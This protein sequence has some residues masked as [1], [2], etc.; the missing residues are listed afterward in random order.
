MM[1][2]EKA[3]YTAFKGEKIKLAGNFLELGSPAPLL[4][5]PNPHLEPIVVGGEGNRVQV[6]L[7]VPSFDTPVCA[8]EARIFNEKL[9]S[10]EGVEGVLVSMDLPF[11]AAHFCTTEGIKNLDF[12]SD[13]KDKSFAKSYGVLI[14]QGPL[15]GLCARAIFIVS[16]DGRIIY[17][18]V[19]PEITDEPNYEEVLEKATAASKEGASCCGF[20]Q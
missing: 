3:D 15:E 5:L 18:Q 9:S 17:K 13:F 1:F 12:V 2:S 6:I 11:A 10:I 8:K 7:T 14:P 19:V 4:N 20:C 16:K